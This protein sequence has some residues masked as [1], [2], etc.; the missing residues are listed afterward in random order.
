METITLT[1]INIFFCNINKEM[2][3]TGHCHYA[4]VTLKFETTGEMGF[5]VFKETVRQISNFL[6]KD[7][8]QLKGFPGTNEAIGRM[9]NQEM[10]FFDYSEAEKYKGCSFRLFST[11]LKVM[12]VNDE[13]NHSDGFAVYEFL[14]H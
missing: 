1:P 2:N 4:T 7:L 13:N 12:G 10:L 9:I 5:P 3:L 8:K 11:T 6:Q 14:N